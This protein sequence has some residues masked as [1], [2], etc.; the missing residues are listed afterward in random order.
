M[1]DD[2]E[3]ILFSEEII[4]Q[5]VAELAARIDEDYGARGGELALVGALTGSL[6][7]LADLTRHIR[8]PHAVDTIRAR[9]YGASTRSSG[10][11]RVT[12]KPLLDLAGK[13]V[14]LVEDI[15]DTGRT[16]TRLLEH[17]RACNPRSLEVC[18]MF[19]KRGRR[20][21]RVN[22]KYRG[23]EI[24]DR[25]IVGYGLDY[26]EKYRNLPYVGVL[27]KDRIIEAGNHAGKKR[28]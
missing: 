18:V 21:F 15:Y 24:P 3:T 13:H 8:T 28:R 26:N 9:S 23:F 25:F 4:A 16:I 10:A 2:I 11:V 22:V 7:F 27:R 20:L 5:R 19:S 14:L 12:H 1:N 6:V 17:L